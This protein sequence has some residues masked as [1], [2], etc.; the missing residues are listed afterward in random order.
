MG[1][2]GED[3]QGGGGKVGGGKRKGIR[4]EIG[5]SGPWELWSPKGSDNE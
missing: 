5:V 4:E 2:K 1:G 3:C